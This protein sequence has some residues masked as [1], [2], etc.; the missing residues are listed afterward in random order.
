MMP[1]F[2]EATTQWWQKKKQSINEL[3]QL[4]SRLFGSDWQTN[5]IW[6]TLSFLGEEMGKFENTKDG[7]WGKRY[8]ST[9]VYLLDDSVISGMS[10]RLREVVRLLIGIVN[11]GVGAE[12]VL[13]DEEI[14]FSGLELTA[15]NKDYFAEK[16]KWLNGSQVAALNSALSNL[17]SFVGTYRPDLQNLGAALLYFQP[18]DSY[19]TARELLYDWQENKMK[20]SPAIMRFLAQSFFAHDGETRD[21]AFDILS[22]ADNGTETEDNMES[23]LFQL[24]LFFIVFDEF[25]S[26][27]PADKGALVN[28]YLWC[29]L[30][31]GVPC[32]ERIKENLALQP[33]LDYYINTS[34]FLADS[35]LHN[36]EVFLKNENEPITIG[37]FINSFTVACPDIRDEY[38]NAKQL[39][40]INRQI[41]IRGQSVQ[42]KELLLEVLRTYLHLRDC[43]LIDYRLFLSDIGKK[44][45][46]YDWKKL[47]LSDL[48]E[49]K[50]EEI[51]K[52]FM[53][54]QRPFAL[55][56]DMIV[57]FGS[58]GWDE[59][60]YLDR[61]LE[62]SGI[63]EE[64][65]P[66]YG[67]L[68]YFSEEDQ[69]WKLNATLPPKLG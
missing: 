31:F 45:Y 57:A 52:F 14:D 50:K 61:I 13:K 28:K 30:C 23:K 19:N 62:L 63:Y 16:F 65:Y 53:M 32:I 3:N 21:L 41:N 35:L 17:T 15:I 48:T 44:E 67:A 47:I 43:D 10:E 33:Y 1:Q 55:R 66:T 20:D 51:R 39:D 49:Q 18:A 60:P 12:A 9:V 34:G 2:L 38:D 56:V 4:S 37:K 64:V 5:T 69:N 25:D 6:Q 29:A 58:M 8:F 42:L 46:P 54:A 26:F 27:N 22:V 36:E 68:V 24:L 59:S 7:G 40:F 11:G